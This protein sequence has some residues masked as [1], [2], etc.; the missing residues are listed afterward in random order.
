[1]EVFKP[2]NNYTGKKL[3]EFKTLSENEVKSVIM[4]MATT[5]CELDAIPTALLKKTLPHTIKVITCI[6]NIQLISG[7][8][9]KGLEN[10]TGE[11][12]IEEASTRI[13]VE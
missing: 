4:S 2:M 1:M 11:T 13:T 8:I 10:G 5:N 9:C 6:V 7:S 12:I 3:A